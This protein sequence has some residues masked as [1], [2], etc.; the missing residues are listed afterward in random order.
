MVLTPMRKGCCQLRYTGAGTGVAVGG[1]V[2]C[3]TTTH[4]SEGVAV[5]RV[6]RCVTRR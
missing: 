2:R 3:D 6:T 5:G 4:D 1:D